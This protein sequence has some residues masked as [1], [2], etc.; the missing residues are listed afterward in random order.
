MS[1]YDIS[2]KGKP[3]TTY[4]NASLLK[5]EDCRQ[6]YIATQAPLKKV[7]FQNFWQMVAENKVSVI[8]MITALE[9][10]GKR[11]ADQYWPDRG[12]TSVSWQ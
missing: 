6:K 11:K 2:L 7:S 1:R 3:P 9:E 5:F 10:R 4:I 8:V 12:V